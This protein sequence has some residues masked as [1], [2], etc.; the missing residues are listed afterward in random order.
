MND[1]DGLLAVFGEV[2][3]ALDRLEAKPP[4]HCQRGVAQSGKHL[5]RMTGVGS[6]LILPVGDV[7][8]PA[9]SAVRLVMA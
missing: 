8:H 2:L 7:A 1:L 3:M 9:L 6:P 4:K 5:W